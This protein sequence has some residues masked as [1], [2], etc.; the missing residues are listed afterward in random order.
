MAGA[1]DHCVV[2]TLIT[3]VVFSLCQTAPSSS[4]DVTV[5]DQE[6]AKH[7]LSQF[8]PVVGSSGSK[9]RGIGP[10]NFT[11][12]LQ[13]MQE[14]FGLEVTGKLDSN[15]L[16][17]MSKP[18]CGVSDVSRYQHF[19]GSPKWEKSKVTYRITQYTRHLNQKEVDATISQA[20]KLYSD[21]IPLDFQQIN[22][23]TADI[24]ILF[25]GGYHGDS[26][27]FDGP[28]GVLAHAMSPGQGVGGDTHFDDDE[29]WT[30][31]Q[32][33][34]NLLLVAAHEF[35]HALGL[36]HSRDRTALMYPNYKYVDTRGYKLPRDDRLGV[37]ALY[38]VR[39]PK[40]KPE[41]TPNLKPEPTPGPKPKPTPEPK[42]GPKPEQCDPDLVFDAATSIMDAL[43]FFKDGYYWKRNS[44]Y[45]DISLNTVKSTWPPIS[46]V[47]AAYEYRRK[48]VAFLF[49]GG[50]YWG[51]RGETILPSY[52]KPISKFG[53]PSSVTKIDSALHV[54][55]SGRTLFFVQN[56][57]W[58]FN[59]R[60]G[61]MDRGY[62]RYIAKDFRGIGSKVDAAF[63]FYGFLYL[64]EGAKQSAY[65]YRF[66]RLEPGYLNNEWLDCN[67]QADYQYS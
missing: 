25:K 49:S 9:G 30:L 36:D 52:P 27:P 28:S 54:P 21:V 41:P 66:R 48:N 63:E 12:R 61:R 40:P 55:W 20:F 4:Q 24:M 17:L 65:N 11:E 6:K 22:S 31:T 29:K 1:M 2:F 45:E 50:Q 62:P 34:I 57:Y 37:Q 35:G 51:V 10:T 18:R 38:G 43:Y 26:S 46:S 13:S 7:Y 64:S 23:G 44:Y 16:E 67:N 53:F 14:F 60:R 56:K 19:S 59:E 8:F 32:R 58:S 39:T 47:D 5:E 3:A 33:G 42:P 15:T